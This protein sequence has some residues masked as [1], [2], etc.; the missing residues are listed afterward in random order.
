MEEEEKEERRSF[1]GSFFLFCV[2]DSHSLA[3][4]QTDWFHFLSF[5]SNKIH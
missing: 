5:C 1:I 4:K 2:D 3:V